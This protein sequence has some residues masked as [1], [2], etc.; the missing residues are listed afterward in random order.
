MSAVG[1]WHVFA[2]GVW[3]MI[4][5]AAW[6]FASWDRFEERDK[7]LSGLLFAASIPALP[8]LFAALVVG[9][10]PVIAIDRSS[11]G[12]KRIGATNDRP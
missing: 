12:G 9:F 8:F 6:P 5:L 1:D 2:V 3:I 11:A 4:T 7:P 10:F